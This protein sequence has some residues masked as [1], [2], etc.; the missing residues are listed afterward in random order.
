MSLY[1]PRDCSLLGSFAHG[2]FQARVLEW[3]AISF[4]R[5]FSDPGIK[6]VSSCIGRLILLALSHQGSPALSFLII[7]NQGV[8]WSL[9]QAGSGAPLVVTH[10]PATLSFIHTF[11]TVMR[12]DDD[13][14]CGK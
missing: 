9:S 8:S 5:D 2:V 3:I 10:P 11:N 6:P 14:N 7:I 13:N 1:D 4:S 12:E